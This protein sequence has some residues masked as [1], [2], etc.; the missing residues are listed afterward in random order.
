MVKILCIGREGRQGTISAMG[1]PSAR[2]DRARRRIQADLDRVL[3]DIVDGR[4]NNGLALRAVGDACG[5]SK[6]AVDRME[7]HVGPSVDL[8]LLA[9]MAAVEGLDLRLALYAGGDPIRDGPPQRLLHRLR[10]R[11]NP[12]LRWGTEVALAIEGDRRAWD[13]E[14][15]GPAWRLPVD[16]E[17]VIDDVQALERRIR[18]KQRDDGAAHVLVVVSAT[19]RNRR[20]LDA[21][22]EAF[23]GYLRDA[24]SVLRA[25]SVGHNPATSAVMF[26]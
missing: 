5:V 9:A 17:T 22:P 1:H 2:V 13:A 14:I 6:S 8:G 19:P 4:R 15:R 25:L 21:A 10:V 24:R 26:L 12:N 16:A 23:A 20:A 18:L 11:L 3:R 7:S